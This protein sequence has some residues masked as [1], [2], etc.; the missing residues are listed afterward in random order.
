MGNLDTER[1]LHQ[2]SK[3]AWDPTR[4]QRPLHQLPTKVAL[5]RQKPGPKGKKERNN[6]TVGQT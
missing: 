3:V 6:R 5:S 2:Y 4:G 1:I